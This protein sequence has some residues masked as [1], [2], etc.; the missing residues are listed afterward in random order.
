MAVVLEK[1]QRAL[2][3]PIPMVRRRRSAN[4]D[5][6]AGV[7]KATK[8][9][10]SPPIVP[11]TPSIDAP[12]MALATGCALAAGVRITTRLPAVSAPVTYSATACSSR[13]STTSRGAKATTAPPANAAQVARERRLR[14]AEAALLQQGEHFV[15][16]MD[17][18]L[19]DDPKDLLLPPQYIAMR[20]LI[21]RVEFLCILRWMSTCSL[22]L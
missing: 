10:S 20:M 14:D 7:R 3:R 4:A 8:I 1:T 19:A 6:V 9:V 5:A 12:S 16:R 15:L 21:H 2:R 17:G 22:S 13:V 18:L 11:R